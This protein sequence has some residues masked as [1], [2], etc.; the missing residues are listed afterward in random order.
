MFPG[1]IRRSKVI[2]RVETA[3]SPIE[4]AVATIEAKS[5]ELEKC[6]AKIEMEEEQ[7]G[8]PEVIAGEVQNL[9]ML[10]NGIVDAAVNGGI[11]KYKEAFL[12]EVRL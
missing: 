10:L 5:V 6:V 11:S 1:F 8:P 2:E 12:N 7:G 4:N 9:G 3:Q